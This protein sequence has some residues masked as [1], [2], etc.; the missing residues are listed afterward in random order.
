MSLAGAMSRGTIKGEE[1]LFKVLAVFGSDIFSL[2]REKHNSHPLLGI[3]KKVNVSSFMDRDKNDNGAFSLREVQP[4]R[5][6]SR[7]YP[8]IGK[9]FDVLVTTDNMVRGAMNAM[10]GRTEESFPFIG[11]SLIDIWTGNEEVMLWSKLDDLWT[12]LTLAGVPTQELKQNVDSLYCYRRGEVSYDSLVQAWA[13]RWGVDVAGI[14]TEWLTMRHEQY[15]RVKEAVSY[16]D[17][18]SKRFKMEGK[19]MNVGKSSGIVSI[20]CGNFFGPVQRFVCCVEPGKAKAFTLVTD[21]SA[22]CINTGLSANVPVAFFFERREPGMLTKPW[23]LME[24]WRSIP[25]SEFM[26]EENPDEMII[27]DQDAGFEVKN[28]NL[29]L[30]QKSRKAPSRLVGFCTQIEGDAKL[31]KRVIDADACGDAIRGYHY[32]GGRSGKS[33][34]TWRLNLPEAGR[35]RVMGKVYRIYLRPQVVVMASDQPV[36]MTPIDDSGIV[37]YYTLSF[38]DQKQD[39]EVSLDNELSGSSGWVTLGDYDFPAGEVSVTLSYKEVRKRREVAIV[40]D[41]VKFIKLE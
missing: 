37:Y 20:E 7:E 27:D 16:F 41:A 9:I 5:I 39:V 14:V 17:P 12:R 2:T 6:Y 40:A 19:V 32:I 1:H 24:E 11:R 23:E 21:Q 33:T 18:V 22:S 3:G 25:V 36:E 26:K 10:I 34:A 4:I 38:G 30:F 13:V 35:Y 28:G 8:F 15:F 29:A 31:W